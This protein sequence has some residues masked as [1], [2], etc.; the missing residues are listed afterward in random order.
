V[1]A[2]SEPAIPLPSDQIGDF[3]SLVAALNRGQS[4]LA[5]DSQ[6]QP[7]L[8]GPADLDFLSAFNKA[9]IVAHLGPNV[10]ETGQIAH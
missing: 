9:N 8:F 10:D 3:K 7:N 4:G 2:S 5:R 1:T 6:F